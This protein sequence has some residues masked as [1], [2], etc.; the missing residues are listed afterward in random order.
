MD[1]IEVIQKLDVKILKMQEMFS[2]RFVRLEQFVHTYLQFQMIFDEIKQ[3]TQDAIFYLDS[4]KSELNMLSMQHLSTNTISCKASCKYLQLPE[5]FGMQSQ[6]ERSDPLQILLR[7]RNLSQFSLLNNAKVDLI[8]LEKLELSSHLSG[9]RQVPL[10]SL[11]HEKRA[12]ESSDFDY[13]RNNFNWTIV[14]VI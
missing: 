5:Y 9:L 10:Q 12:F 1:L 11:F 3:T 8:K 14:T 2:Q 6:F 4:L 7:M 13:S